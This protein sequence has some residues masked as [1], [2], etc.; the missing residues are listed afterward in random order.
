MFS[1]MLES[2]TRKVALVGQ[3]IEDLSYEPLDYQRFT[4]ELYR[5]LVTS[6]L[7]RLE[8][9]PHYKDNG[10]FAFTDL[11][12]GDYYLVVFGERFQNQQLPIT[13]PFAPIDPNSTMQ[14]RLDRVFFDQPGD[15][16][17]IVVVKTLNANRITFDAATIRR[18]IFSGSAVKANGAETRLAE[19]LDPGKV[20]SARLESVTG[21]TAGAIVRIIRDRSIRLRFDPY[22]EALAESTR[23]SG[24]VTLLNQADVVLPGALIT[25]TEV[26]S[27]AVTVTDIGGA[28]VATVVLGGSGTVL[29]TERDLQTLT[30]EKGD[31]TLYFGG[32]GVTKV[33]L[34]ATLD[35]YQTVT[36][37]DVAV[38][39]QSRVRAEFQLARI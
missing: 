25:I 7:D 14:Q 6:K 12:P 8:K 22:S 1:E 34:T 20:T 5:R 24:Q 3:V 27:T 16:E 26:N 35:G 19:K 13:I 21:I 10:Y 38:S 33:T 18:S 36:K 29:G 32:D 28:R 23:I 39:L 30:N 37:Q 31:Y 9:T 4:A 17:L 2:T 11:L 15:N